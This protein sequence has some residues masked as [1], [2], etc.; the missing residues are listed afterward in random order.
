[1]WNPDGYEAQKENWFNT[2]LVVDILRI[3]VFN[4]K[5]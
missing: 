4:D 1:M 5:N 3:L 2:D